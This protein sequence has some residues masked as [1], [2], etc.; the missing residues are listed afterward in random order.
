MGL[1]LFDSMGN[2]VSTKEV[3]ERLTEWYDCQSI[4]CEEGLT[5]E[6]E[7]LVLTILTKDFSPGHTVDTFRR[8]VSTRRLDNDDLGIIAA[9]ILSS[10]PVARAS[11]CSAMPVTDMRSTVY[12]YLVGRMAAKDAKAIFDLKHDIDMAVEIMTKERLKA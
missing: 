6:T 12:A 1:D 2:P 10:N 3:I 11:F 7:G 5:Q 9:E 4:S 8:A